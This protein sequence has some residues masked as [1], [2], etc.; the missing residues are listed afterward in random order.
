M[1]EREIDPLELGVERVRPGGARGRP[2]AEN[3]EAIRG[4][5]E[6]R[7]DGGRRDAILLNAAGAIAAG[8]GADDLRE[9]LEL[10]R[11]RSTRAPPRS[12]S[13]SWRLHAEE[14]A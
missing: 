12:G 10:A 8:G 1:R 4:V 3:A 5:F 6:G 11:G 13:S 2:P 7:G 14:A 9:G